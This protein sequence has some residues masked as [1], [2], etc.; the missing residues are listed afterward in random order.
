MAKDCPCR[1]CVPP[2]RNAD[3]HSYCPEY[4]EWNAEHQEELAKIRE[5]NRANDDC[6][7]N[8]LRNYK[9]RRPAYGYHKDD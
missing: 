4:K 8:K 2:K 7:P 6:F 3:C 9:K 1:Y 5:L